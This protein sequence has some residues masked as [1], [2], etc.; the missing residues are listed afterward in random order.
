MW[1]FLADWSGRDRTPRIP[2]MDPEALA[3][4][5]TS[6]NPPRTRQLLEIISAALT[7]VDPEALVAD[8]LA[9][10]F[11]PGKRPNPM[12]ATPSGGRVIV[13]SVGKAAACMARGAV[14]A[15]DDMID[16]GIVVSD[17]F[18]SVAP[19]FETLITSHPHPDWRSQAAGLRALEIADKAE[20]D[21]LVLF[22]IS[23]GASSLLEV[24]AAGIELAEVQE[25]T[26]QLIRSGAPIAD[27]NTVRTHLSA[28]KGGR[29]AAAAAPARV[30]T[31]ILSDV[32]AAAA[33]LVGS[34]PS[35]ASPTTTADALA[36]LHRHGILGSSTKR[37][38]AVLENSR[39]PY[40]VETPY[41][42]IGDCRLAAR[43]AAIRADQMKIPVR[44]VG[45]DLV[46]E[47]RVA[48]AAA[49]AIAK[50]GELT[51]LTGETTVTVQGQGSGGR[52]QEA[53]LAAAIEIAGHEDAFVAFGTDGID[54]PTDAAGAVVDG[55]T[56]ERGRLIGLDAER[57][58]LNNDS[59]PYL[60]AVG[61]VIRC[62]PTGTN[63]GD[64]WLID[65]R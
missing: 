6:I 15:L 65:R 1:R 36:V 54:G 61:A 12:L 21:D 3:R 5:I 40:L 59:N 20:A 37:L 28:L 45:R 10:D 8:A 26:A 16:H 30:W 2:V 9:A 51:I 22:L 14:R 57:H 31:L 25:I 24:P 17:H 47:A 35:V 11:G 34:G 46:G 41:L 56:V 49:I 58:L 39:R 33:H 23:G 48:A 50:R 44:V 4:S 62:G 27:L 19:P 32:G 52:S 18:E 7:A 64:L 60:A 29:L 38:G 43:A 13:I 55:S 42:V 53:A 63:V